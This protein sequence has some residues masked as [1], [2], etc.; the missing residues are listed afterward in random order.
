MLTSFYWV[1]YR[2]EYKISWIFY[3]FSQNNFSLSYC[4]PYIYIYFS[5][6]LFFIFLFI[7]L[8]LLIPLHSRIFRILLA[9][10]HFISSM[11]TSATVRISRHFNSRITVQERIISSDYKSDSSKFLIHSFHWMNVFSLSEKTFIQW[12][13]TPVSIRTDLIH[14]VVAFCPPCWLPVFCYLHLY[15]LLNVANQ[16]CQN[17]ARE[18]WTLNQLHLCLS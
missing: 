12:K 2:E 7:S 3:H 10:F 15:R 8:F 1:S 11:H 5:L 13:E 9:F 18:S 14:S 6:S 17:R 16:N 4:L